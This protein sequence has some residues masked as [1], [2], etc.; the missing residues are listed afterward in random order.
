MEDPEYKKTWAH[1]TP[2][3]SAAYPSD[4]AQTALF[5]VSEQARHITG[6]TIVVDGGWSA[7]SPSP[8]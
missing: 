7:V 2:I 8:Y 3:G 1:L 6:Q 5:L 4:I